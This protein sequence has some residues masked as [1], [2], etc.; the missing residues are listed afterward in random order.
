M[1]SPLKVVIDECVGVES[2]LFGEFRAWLGTGAAEFL[3]L[4]ETH[5]GIP[6]VEILDKLLGP[7][8]VLL[9][10]DCV[11][12]NRACASKRRSFTLNEQQ[13]LTR[14]PLK[15]VRTPHR[16]TAP[17]VFKQLKP[18]YASARHEIAQ[19]LMADLPGKRLKG[20]RTARRRIRSYF[21]S[22]ANISRVAL[23]IGTR[24]SRGR[25]LCGYVL[26]IAGHTGVKGLAASEGY[27]TVASSNYSE[28]HCLIHGLCAVFCLYLDQTPIDIFIMP[29]KALN[30]CQHTLDGVATSTAGG[31]SGT[32][33]MMLGALPEFHLFPC[34]K[35][36]FFDAMTRKLERLVSGGSN[37][38][39][40]IDFDDIARRL[41]SPGSVP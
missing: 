39:R 32:L 37:E 17:S 40:S 12:H 21:G 20:L 23:T 18:S 3:F 15:N 33:K 24:R 19:R 9:T 7:G 38:V 5:P 26:R 27:C 25:V 10:N 2:R 34:V 22:S 1:S 31:N 13:Q 35:G 28:A 30:F 29:G 16:P 41:A 4:A 11:L 8:V 36:R 6:D 14:R